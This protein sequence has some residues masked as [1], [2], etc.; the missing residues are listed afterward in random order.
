MDFGGFL[1]ILVDFG[2]FW[3]ILVDF[4]GFR[5]TCAQ[6]DLRRYKNTSE[7][8]ILVIYTCF[9]MCLGWVRGGGPGKGGR[10]EGK[11]SPWNGSQTSDRRV[12]GFWKHFGVMWGSCWDHF[13]VIFES[14]LAPH[15]SG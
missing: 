4:G 12:D 9:T 1:W 6:R 8:S 11:P 7:T 2:G 15:R 5:S 14:V 10:G 13:G 3:K